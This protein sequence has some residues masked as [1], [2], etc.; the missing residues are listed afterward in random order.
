MFVCLRFVLL[1][2]SLPRALRALFAPFGLFKF[3]PWDDDIDLS[4]D[5]SKSGG[6]VKVYSEY[7]VL[8]LRPFGWLLPVCACS[9]C[10]LAPVCLV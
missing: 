2:L 4:I 5:T 9:K 7:P 3:I 1:R 10:V 6:K 8:R